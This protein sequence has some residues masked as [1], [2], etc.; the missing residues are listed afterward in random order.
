MIIFSALAG[1]M[2]MRLIYADFFSN[3]DLIG[4]C[5][6]FHFREISFELNSNLAGDGRRRRPLMML[7]REWNNIQTLQ[8]DDTEIVQNFFFFA[9]AGKF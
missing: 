3:C 5:S 6:V 2:L 4:R 7:M 1:V 8:Q 9:A